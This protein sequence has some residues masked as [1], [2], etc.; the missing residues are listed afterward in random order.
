MHAG[1]DL[2]IIPPVLTRRPGAHADWERDAGIEEVRR[3]AEAAE[4]LGYD[5]VSCCEHVAVPRVRDDVG[6]VRPGETYWDP[7]PVFGHLA[8]H[9]SRIHFATLVL[10]VPH[11]HPLDIAKQYGTLDRIC[12]GRLVLGLGVGYSEPEFELLGTPFD[13]RGQRADDVIRALRASF[14]R[15]DP[16]YHGRFFDFEDFVIDPCGIQQDVPIWIG[17]M[18]RRSLRRAVELGDAWSPFAVSTDNVKRWVHAASETEAWHRRTN[19]L[20]LVLTPDEPI[21]PLGARAETLAIAHA[22]QDAGASKLTLRFAHD[23]LEHYLEQLEAMADVVL[24]L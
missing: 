19:P 11:H 15:V 22:L 21:D 17:G 14:G 20:T 12:D 10:V 18:S 5:F 2:G 8:A 13:D 24:D 16:V 1:L 3:I 9:T 7:L 23:S 4:R 6:G